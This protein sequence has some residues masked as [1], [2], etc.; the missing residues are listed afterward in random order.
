MLTSTACSFQTNWA[1]M[2]GLVSN[3]RCLNIDR[4]TALKSG[5]LWTF[6]DFFNDFGQT[7]SRFWLQ[8]SESS[9]KTVANSEKLPNFL[10][11]LESMTNNLSFETN[12]TVLAQ[13]DEK[14]HTIKDG[15]SKVQ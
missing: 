6:E 2:L 10:G 11:D 13:F 8:F 5:K 12:L 15:Y 4:S 9:I 7:S 1:K 3:E 14:W